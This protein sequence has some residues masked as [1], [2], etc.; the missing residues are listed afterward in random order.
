[1]HHNNSIPL[2]IIFTFIHGLIWSNDP[3]HHS[4]CTLAQHIGSVGCAVLHAHVGECGEITSTQQ[5]Q[6]VCGGST[7]PNPTV[8]VHDDCQ[9]QT[10]CKKWE[11]Q[12]A[13]TPSSGQVATHE[14][15][16]ERP[17]NGRELVHLYWSKLYISA[18]HNSNHN[19]PHYYWCVQLLRMQSSKCYYSAY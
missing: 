4:K 18:Q 5:H 15:P 7:S 6:L 19:T 1:M 14:Y 16:E 3:A 11:V 17:G 9:A 12:I 13:A 8:P 10:V 2:T